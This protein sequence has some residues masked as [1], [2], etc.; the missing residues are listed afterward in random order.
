M[1]HDDTDDII[2]AFVHLK[3]AIMEPFRLMLELQERWQ[4]LI[5]GLEPVLEPIFIE[6]QKKYHEFPSQLRKALL[7][8][9]NHGWYL[10]PWEMT[11]PDLWKL[12][13]ALSE[14]NIEEA[15]TELIEHFERNLDK[16]EKSIIERFPMRAKLVSAAFGAH[17]KQEYELAIPV[18]LAQTDGICKDIA[19]KYLFIKS[20]NKPDVATF[21]DHAYTADTVGAAFLSPLTETLSISESEKKRSKDFNGLNR[22]MVLH[23]ESLDYGT[24]QNSLKAISLLNYVA[25]ML[26][27]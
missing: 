7:L 17:R 26:S 5:R 16:I 24:K 8:V 27:N 22:H 19:D 21:V 15:E 13:K 25:T 10:D 3:D 6:L 14:D 12:E 1:K 11:L 4:Q 9:G 23:G 18:F 2:A 20:K